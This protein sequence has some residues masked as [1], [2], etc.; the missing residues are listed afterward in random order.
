MLNH[1]NQA[2]IDTIIAACREDAPANPGADLDSNPQR[3]RVYALVEALPMDAQSELL[4]LM[5]TGGPKNA[6]SLAENLDIV[7]RTGDENHAFH[8]AEQA[9]S[10]PA[11]L[12]EGLR[13]SGAVTAQTET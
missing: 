8:I 13:K 6:S 10:L 3:D 5:W 12:Q 2:D 1:L 7:Q 9:H 4:A 11:L